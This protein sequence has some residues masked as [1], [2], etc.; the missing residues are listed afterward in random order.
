[1]FHLCPDEYFLRSDLIYCS[2]ISI[3]LDGTF[4]LELSTLK[5]GCIQMGHETI[6]KHNLSKHITDYI[7][8]HKDS[9]QILP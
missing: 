2:K 5:L 6:D 4:C 9:N 7:S 8:G 1:M 3:P